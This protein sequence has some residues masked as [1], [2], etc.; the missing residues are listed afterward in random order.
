MTTLLICEVTVEIS[1]IL[2]LLK[3][4]F[5]TYECLSLYYLYQIGFQADATG[6]REFWKK[7]ETEKYVKKEGTVV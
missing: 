1:N 4:C 3:S 7:N 2:L 6:W 5:W